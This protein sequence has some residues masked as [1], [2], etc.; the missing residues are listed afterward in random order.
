[1][2]EMRDW[3]KEKR[4]VPEPADEMSLEGILLEHDRE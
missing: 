4:I 3:F 1:M 2:T